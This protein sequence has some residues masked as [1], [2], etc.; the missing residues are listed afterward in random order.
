MLESVLSD[1]KVVDVTSM[2]A[3]PTMARFFAELGANVIHV[4]PPRGDDGRNSGSAYLGR[5]APIFSASNRSKRGMVVDIKQHEGQ[6]I[7]RRLA[8][9]ADLFVQN[10]PPGVMEKYGLGYEDLSRINPALVY[11]SISAWGAAGPLAASPGYDVLFQGFVGTMRKPSEDLPPHFN[12]SYGADPT[13]PMLAAFAAMVAL[14]RR[15]RTGVGAHVQT[16]LLEATMDNI[17]T[18]LVLADAETEIASASPGRALG[19]LGAFRCLD[20]DY[21]VIC[22]WTDAQFQK[23][24]QLADLAHIADEPKYCGREGRIEDG[25]ALNE[26]LDNWTSTLGRTE[27]VA[28]L[29][30]EGIPC[31]PVRGGGMRELIED[32]QIQANGLITAIDHPTKGLM[33][34]TSP[35]YTID[36][37]RAAIRPA[38]MLGQH[39]DE[40][41]REHGLSPGEIADL[42]SG[43]VVA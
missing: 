36:G 2:I 18:R 3:G 35:A 15:D 21:A 40:V 43:G 42:R 28:H 14:R 37:E 9:D 27:L 22:A 31:A 7:L 38:P 16:S 17:A 39:T 5:E 20:G 23:L 10:S 6:R 33:W 4:E 32:P 34:F 30:S 25:I 11:V 1:L 19:G 41:L 29:R 24:C 26:V 8:R 12:G 13:A